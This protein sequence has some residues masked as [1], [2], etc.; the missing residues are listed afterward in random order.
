MSIK[1]RGALCAALVVLATPLWAGSTL[2]A[3]GRIEV[4]F[5]PHDDVERLVMDQIDGAKQAV[6]VQAY[7][8]TSRGI[9]KTLIAAA[10]RG[11]RVEVVADRDLVLKDDRSAL[12]RAAGNG[13][14]VWLDGRY[15][16]AHSKVMIVD[17]D[18]K[19][20][21]VITGSYNF[22]HSGA[23]RNAEN[24]IVLSGNRPLAQ[25]YLD[26]WKR[27]RAQSVSFTDAVIESQ[28]NAGKERIAPQ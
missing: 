20:P 1:L 21:V 17:P 18:G 10:Q 4:G 26:N 12:P 15:A 5:A 14:A 6:Y 24:V 23:T 22:S 11:I 9:V 7:S 3:E 28:K 13:V 27:H 8:L 2:P 25:A 19:E 16:M